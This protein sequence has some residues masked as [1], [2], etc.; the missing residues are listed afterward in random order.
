[1]ILAV[2]HFLSIVSPVRLTRV[3]TRV[4]NFS[5]ESPLLSF[6]PKRIDGS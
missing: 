2:Y 6:I 1:V 5:H 3:K 4:L